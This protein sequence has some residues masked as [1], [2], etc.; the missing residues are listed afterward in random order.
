MAGEAIVMGTLG[1]ELGGDRGAQR[2]S[3]LITF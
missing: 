1:E 3:A 2:F